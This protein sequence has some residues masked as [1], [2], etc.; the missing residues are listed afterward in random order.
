M[1]FKTWM[2]AVKDKW[3]LTGQRS[4]I[5]GQFVPMK[6]EL[7]NVL[8]VK[9][10]GSL[11]IEKNPDYAVAYVWEGKWNEGILMSIG[12]IYKASKGG[13]EDVSELWSNDAKIQSNIKLMTLDALML[14]IMMMLLSLFFKGGTTKT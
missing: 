9:D 8:Y 12:R 13:F 10:D 14:M 2:V 11:T 3:I 1:H 4:E 7:G 5:L 6:D